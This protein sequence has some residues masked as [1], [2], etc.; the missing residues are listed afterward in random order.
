[1]IYGIANAAEE[2]WGATA[3]VLPIAVGVVVLAA[4]LLWE[5]QAE[6]PLLP[7]GILRDRTRAGGFLT[8]AVVY[9]PGTGMT[10]L[11]LLYLQ[12]PGGEDALT[13][14]LHFLPIPVTAIFG[15]FA[16]MKL[17]PRVPAARIVA[18][19][20]SW[21]PSA[22]SHLTQV[23]L[24]ASFTRDMLPGFVLFG[25]GSS[26]MFV[27]GNAISL[28]GVPDRDTGLASALINTMQ[29]VGAALGVAILSTVASNATSDYVAENGPGSLPEG[30][31]YGNDL[32][33]A[34]GAILLLGT[35]LVAALLIRGDEPAL[36]PTGVAPEVSDLPVSRQPVAAISGDQPTG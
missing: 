35:G 19:G 5:A 6:N 12:G 26:V 36:E 16:S 31:V 25:L 23:D 3:T 18:G 22:L 13:A 2:G 9:G 21:P 1:M 28:A 24:G 30:I 11:L 27:A 32:A 15:A 8:M 14:G 34:L 17:L 10:L 20:S 33:F 29:Q 4:F 7:L